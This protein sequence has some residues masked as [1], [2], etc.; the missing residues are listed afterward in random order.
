MT[1]VATRRTHVQALLMFF[2]EQLLL[3]RGATTLLFLNTV[4]LKNSNRLV[5]IKLFKKQP[6]KRTQTHLREAAK[7]KARLGLE[8][9]TSVLSDEEKRVDGEKHI[10]RYAT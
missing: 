7:V 9:L 5:S 8:I 4:K 6:G 1:R 10:R 3:K 2:C